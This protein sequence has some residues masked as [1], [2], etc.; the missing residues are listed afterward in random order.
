MPAPRSP[1]LALTILAVADVA[2]AARFYAA[3]FGWKQTFDGSPHYAEFMLGNGTGIGLYVHRGFA[4]QVGAD[5]A[6]LPPGTVTGT[7]LYVRVDDLDSAI[8]ALV[9]AGAR[10][11]SPR[12]R[13]VWGEEA[14]YFAD[15]DGHV[16]AVAKVLDEHD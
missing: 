16:V 9:A 3:A 10:P 8:A 6:E 5:V 13:R 2:R 14:A 4:G 15:P 1:H 12:A 11:L 7:E